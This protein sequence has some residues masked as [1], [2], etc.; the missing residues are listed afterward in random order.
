V[1]DV[2]SKPTCNHDVISM[3]KIQPFAIHPHQRPVVYSPMHVLQV[4]DN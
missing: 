4:A 1:V 2:A 3:A